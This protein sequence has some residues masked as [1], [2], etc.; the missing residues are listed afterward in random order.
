[1]HH[2]PPERAPLKKTWDG[3]TPTTRPFRTAIPAGWFIEP[4]AAMTEAVP[5]T[6]ARATTTPVKKCGHRGSLLQ[7]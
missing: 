1:M 2:L 7:P 5:P 3:I 4:L 6:P